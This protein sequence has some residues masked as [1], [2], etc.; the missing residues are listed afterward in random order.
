M[1][2]SFS[3]FADLVVELAGCYWVLFSLM[4]GGLGWG[5]GMTV[6]CTTDNRAEQWSSWHLVDSFMSPIWFM[7]YFQKEGANSWK[8]VVTPP[9]GLLSVTGLLFPAKVIGYNKALSDM[10]TS[11]WFDDIPTLHI[12]LG[13]QWFFSLSFSLLFLVGFFLSL[14]NCIDTSTYLDTGPPTLLVLDF[15]D[16]YM[17][18]SPV[19]WGS[20]HPLILSRSRSQVKGDQPPSLLV[21][22]RELCGPRGVFWCEASGYRTSSPGVNTAEAVS[23]FHYTPFTIV[24]TVGQRA[25]CR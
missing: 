17:G 13:F 12:V 5:L 11:S 8:D 14:F 18:S 16:R 6:W 10:Q 22:G 9:Q 4:L 1:V 15:R 20:F 2:V 3:F 7:C 23:V 21:E 24:D 25:L 19:V